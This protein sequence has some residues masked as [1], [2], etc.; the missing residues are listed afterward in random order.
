MIKKLLSVGACILIL[1]SC[2]S[3]QSEAGSNS[4]PDR[5]QVRGDLGRIEGVRSNLIEDMETKCYYI[6]TLGYQNIMTLSPYIVHGKP[7]CEEDPNK[8]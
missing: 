3:V 8:G 4:Q 2:S 7:Y 6:E 5:F 1:S